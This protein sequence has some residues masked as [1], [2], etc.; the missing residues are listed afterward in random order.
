MADQWKEL[1]FRKEDVCDSCSATLPI[2]VKDYWS[3]TA[4][5]IRCL[6]HSVIAQPEVIAEESRMREPN[7]GTAGKSAKEKYSELQNTEAENVRNR[8]G[9]FKRLREIAVFLLDDAQ[10]TAN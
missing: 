5:K 7:R 1:V 4:K 3:S 10:K 8:F 9:R 6:K 2:G